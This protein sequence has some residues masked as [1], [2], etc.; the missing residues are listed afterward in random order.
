LLKAHG[1]YS[2]PIFVLTRCSEFPLLRKRSKRYVFVT[3]AL[4]TQ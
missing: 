2:A 4:K 3:Q 1:C